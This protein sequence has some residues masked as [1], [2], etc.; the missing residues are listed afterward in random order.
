[1]GAFGDFID[2]LKGA[3]EDIGHGHMPGSG[4]ADTCDT[5]LSRCNQDKGHTGLHQCDN[6]HQ[7]GEH[8]KPLIPISN[9]CPT[10]CT[11]CDDKCHQVLGH[12]GSHRCGNGHE[13][14]QDVALC[15]ASCPF[16]QCFGTCVFQVGHGGPHKCG[17]NQ[18]SYSS[19]WK[20]APGDPWPLGWK[21]GDP[22]PAGAQ[23]TNAPA[24]AAPATDGGSSPADGGGSTSAPQQSTDAGAD[25]S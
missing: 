2:Y 5:C 16:E 21:P 7:W 13:W 24:P 22:P 4:C 10:K 1:M 6:N 8:D 18:H 3:A 20:P 11:T 9:F 19:T 17:S 14:Q 25:G 23:T 15:Q 12:G